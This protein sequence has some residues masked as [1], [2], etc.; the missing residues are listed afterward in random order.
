[1]TRLPKHKRVESAPRMILTERDKRIIL[2]VY[3][4]RYL[5]RG[6]IER[7][8]CLGTTVA[9]RRLRL[10]FQHGYLERMFQPV[11]FGSLRIVYGLDR[12]GAEIIAQKL[13]LD[14]SSLNWKRRNSKVE[15]L[16][17]EH[18]LAISD[19]RVSLEASLKCRP[20][21]L[22]LFWQRENKDLNCRVSDPTG[23]SKYITVNPDAFFGI[24]SPRGKSYYFLEADLG[25]ESSKRF[26]RKIVAYRQYWKSGK[27]Q[28]MYGFGSFRVLTVTTGERRLNNLLKTANGLGAKSMFLFVAQ[29]LTITNNLFGKIWLAP[30]CSDY[31]SILD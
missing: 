6:Q 4:N 20:D 13:N 23:K 2:S 1:M 9:N 5:T 8:F 21:S 26:E 31:I 3:E 24:L 29:E 22:L 12:K 16:F 27:Y 7:L 11:S 14:M 17:M 28:E 25:T 18:T 30:N 10:M 19:F 15:F